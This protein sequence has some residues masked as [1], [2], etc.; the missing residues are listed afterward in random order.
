MVLM[1]YKCMTYG[2]YTVCTRL[3]TDCL[4]TLHAAGEWL[5]SG[6]FRQESIGPAWSGLRENG[7]TLIVRSMDLAEYWAE[8]RTEQRGAEDNWEEQ[9]AAQPASIRSSSNEQYR[10]A[11]LLI[12]SWRGR[13]SLGFTQTFRRRSQKIDRLPKMGNLKIP[14]YQIL[15]FKFGLI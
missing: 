15:L 4:D 10:P 5:T 8:R 9:R 11:S 2:L 12:N 6:D 13:N 3:H 1:T 7:K 14:V